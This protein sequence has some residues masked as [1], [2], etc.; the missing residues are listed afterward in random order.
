MDPR[1]PPYAGGRQIVP[2]IPSG[3]PEGAVPPGARFDP[4]GPV[5]PDY[6]FPGRGGRLPGD[7][8]PRGGVGFADPNPDHLRPPPDGSDD[9]F[10]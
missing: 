3:L 9:M 2:P 1:H 6:M 10:M 5:N 8:R 7:P 4:F